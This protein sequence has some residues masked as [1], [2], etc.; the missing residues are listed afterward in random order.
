MSSLLMRNRQITSIH[1]DADRLPFPPLAL[2]SSVRRKNYRPKPLSWKAR[3]LRVKCGRRRTHKTEPSPACRVA[4]G[5]ER[6]IFMRIAR[7]T[8][9]TWTAGYPIRSIAADSRK[10]Y[11]KPIYLLLNRA[12]GRVEPFYGSI[13]V[14]GLI[15]SRRRP[16]K[17]FSDVHE[18]YFQTSTFKYS[19]SRRQDTA[20]DV[21]KPTPKTARRLLGVGENLKQ[22]SS[23]QEQEDALKL[24]KVE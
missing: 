6:D 1:R 7:I 8:L 24:C 18:S 19:E 2:S 23:T 20:D 12:S 21:S 15:Q 14:Y 17:L 5:L 22:T 9:T 10:I 4:I 3:I 11:A 13:L 16:E